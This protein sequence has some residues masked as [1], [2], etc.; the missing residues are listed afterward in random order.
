MNLYSMQ[1]PWYMAKMRKAMMEII[2]LP[3]EVSTEFFKT[4]GEVYNAH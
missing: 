4:W 1:G 3:F 2:A